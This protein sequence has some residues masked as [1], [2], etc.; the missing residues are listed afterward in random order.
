MSI[1]TTGQAEIKSTSQEEK[2][3][4]FGMS[5]LLHTSVIEILICSLA[6][7]LCL[8]FSQ[9]FVALVLCGWQPTGT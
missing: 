8:V 3:V 1:R 6:K 7:K 4:G 5:Q 9:M 2:E